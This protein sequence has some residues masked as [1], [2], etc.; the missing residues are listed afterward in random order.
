MKPTNLIISAFGPYKNEVQIDFSKIG[1]NGIF[2][3]TGDTGA[4]KTTIF[5]AISFAL[6]GEASG[7]N[8]TVTSVRSNFSDIDIPTFVE[9]EFTHKGKEYKIRR[10]PAYE[11]PK[12]RGEGITKSD[13]DASLE[14]EGEV[15]ASI[16]RDVD[17]KIKEILGIDSKQFKQ[18][19]MLAQG[20]FLKILFTGTDER[21][22]IFRKIFDTNVYNEI[23]QKIAERFRNSKEE[24]Q[25]QKDAF[26]TNVSNINWSRE[27]DKIDIS[28]IKN[29]NQTDVVEILEKL[30]KEIEE[31]KANYEKIENEIKK[32]EEANSKL[33]KEIVMQEEQNK[34][35]DNLNTLK[36]QKK[37]LE[38]NKKQIEELQQKIDK[39]QKIIAKVAPKEEKVK[40]TQN[41]IDTLNKDVASLQASI[42]LARNTQ[43]E[44]QQKIEKLEKLKQQIEKY[45][46]D[47]NSNNELTKILEKIEN[48][49]K[50]ISQKEKVDKK[51]LECESEYKTLNSEYIEKT[52]EYFREQA[53]ILAE[54]LKENE[55]C[56]VCGS[57]THPHL[58]HKSENV[59]TKEELDKLKESVDKSNKE[60]QKCKDDI[61]QLKS[62]IE[63]LIAEINEEKDFDIFE[64][65]KQIRKQYDENKQKNE[66]LLININDI[67]KSITNKNIDINEFKFSKFEESIN[68]EKEDVNAK[69]LEKQ[70]L[71]TE[72]TKQLEEKQQALQKITEEYEAS[73]KELGFESEEEYKNNI[74]SEEEISKNQKSINEYH[75]N[76]QV[77]ESKIKDL[78]P[79]VKDKEKIDLTEK[80]QELE[81]LKIQVENS[82]KVQLQAHTILN[83]NKSINERLVENKN[84]LEKAINEYLILEELDKTAKGNLPG[85]QKIGFEQYVQTT[86]FDMIIIE[87]NKRLARMTDNRFYLIRREASQYISD[88]VALEL[89]VMDNYNGKK[90]DVKSLSGGESFKAALSLALGLSDVIQSYSGGIVV[91][92]LFIDEGFGSLDSESREQAISTLMQLSDNNK[93][94]GIISHVSEL[95][96]ILDKKIIVSKTADGSKVE[97]E[98]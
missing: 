46:Q 50:E 63:T 96:D 34:K 13:A 47:K 29:L 14:C 40:L 22:I 51:Y 38:S 83:T 60:K 69:L 43:I 28:Y 32:L 18:I 62:K 49:N 48:I 6:Y 15:L 75:T 35:I 9:L 20:E 81:N 8:R 95:K 61:T 71:V 31:N 82:K 85:K 79:Q 21:K 97:I 68:K 56:P 11:R 84:T 93:L 88:K 92:T 41:E 12:K 1:D 64:Y 58:A 25:T 45:E 52:D 4:G 54:N 19:A 72:K 86:Y 37:E 39:S 30:E 98:N 76:V 24:L 36:E 59:L 27:E 42:T 70:T 3:V 5:D 26:L 67:Y 44:V 57:T 87:A 77:N 55:E 91:D 23:T 2:L 10:S 78:E 80:H 90:R 17:I 7:S 94:I 66:K 33:E 89:D 53:G 65:E 16:P 74:F 73:Y